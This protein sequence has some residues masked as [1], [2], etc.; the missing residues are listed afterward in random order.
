MKFLRETVYE[1][2]G[3][4]H[5]IEY[6]WRKMHMLIQMLIAE[7]GDAVMFRRVFDEAFATELQ[8]LRELF[9]TLRQL[10]AL[11]VAGGCGP[12]PD[13]HPTVFYTFASAAVKANI[14][15]DAIICQALRKELFDYACHYAE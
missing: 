12:M 8:N 9:A 14:A 15:S 1:A 13:V 3:E 7:Q 4:N 11:Y 5:T 10:L 2:Y 6:E